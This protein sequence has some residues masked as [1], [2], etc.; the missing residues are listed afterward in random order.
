MISNEVDVHEIK[1][2]KWVALKR[3]QAHLR[4]VTEDTPAMAIELLQ[5]PAR[6]PSLFGFD[7]V[8]RWEVGV[9]IAA[10]WT[11]VKE[12]SWSWELQRREEGGINETGD[13]P[14]CL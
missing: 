14:V 11:A 2:G 5:H 4:R 13:G 8:L 9:A 7:V 10:P 3:S 6:S 12:S 1:W